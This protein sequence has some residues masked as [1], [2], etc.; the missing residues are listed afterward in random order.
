MIRKVFSILLAIVAIS[1]IEVALKSSN[2]LGGLSIPLGQFFIA[3]LIWPKPYNSLVQ[4][5]YSYDLLDDLAELDFLKSKLKDSPFFNIWVGDYVVV[6]YNDDIT[7]DKF[8]VAQLKQF[9]KKQLQYLS[10][11]TELKYHSA[12]KR[13]IWF[14]IVTNEKLKRLKKKPYP[15]K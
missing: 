8:A 11:Q 6:A 13:G 3:Y 10:P 4:F 15:F 14:E 2:I 5:G 7:E 9:T 12:D 1:S